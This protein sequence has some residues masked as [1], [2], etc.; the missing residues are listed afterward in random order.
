M[1]LRLETSLSL[2]VVDGEM[3]VLS[4]PMRVHIARTLTREHSKPDLEGT[5]LELMPLT[6][7]TALNIR[8]ESPVDALPRN[9]LLAEAGVF[10]LVRQRTQTSLIRSKRTAKIVVIVT[11]EEE[12]AMA[13]RLP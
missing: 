7:G 6:K 13:N 1:T 4:V 10:E 3:K 12:S 11:W 8:T 9:E 5:Q 2:S